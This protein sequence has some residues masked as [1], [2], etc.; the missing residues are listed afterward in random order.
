MDVG[1]KSEKTLDMHSCRRGAAEIIK[2][3]RPPH[4]IFA[5]LIATSARSPFFSSL[6]NDS[7]AGVQ[8]RYGVQDMLDLCTRTLV[9]NATGEDLD[10]CPAVRAH[11]LLTLV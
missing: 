11:I 2:L 7:A 1:E 6:R 9:G 4:T 8:G 10:A 3:P 5:S